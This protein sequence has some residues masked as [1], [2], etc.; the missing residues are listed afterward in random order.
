[1]RI[2]GIVLLMLLSW[3]PRSAEAACSGSGQSWSCTAGTTVAQVNS[4]LNAAANNATLT[5]DAG[6]YS[7]STAI[8]LPNTRGVTLRCAS[9]GNCNVAVGGTFLGLALSGNNTNVYRLSGFRFQNAPACLCIWIYGPGTLNNLRI[10]N[11]IFQNF[12]GDAIAIFF[13]ATD[14]AGSYYGVIDHNTFTGS[15]NFLALKV[16]GHGDTDAWGPSPKGTANNMF[17]EDNT[18]TFSTAANLGAGCMDVWNSGAVVWRYNT[19]TNCLVTAHGVSHGGVI[20]FEV[21]RNTLIRTA[22]SGGWENG[23]RLFHHQGSGEFIAFDNVFTAAAGAGKSASALAM[24]H[25]R[26]ASPGAAGYDAA[27]GRCDGSQPID[28]NRVPTSTYFG[29]PCW[30]QP[31][32]DGSQRL[33]P[34]YVWNNRWSDTAAKIDLYTENPWNAT[35]PGV[36]TH[37]LVNRDFYNAVSASAQ[38]SP[39]G[40]FNGTTGMGF[41]T[42]ANRPSTC[43]TNTQEAGGGVGYFATDQGP[44]GTLYR[45]SSANTWV[46]QYT[47][48]NYPHPLVSG[49]TVPAPT[50]AAPTNVRLLQ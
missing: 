7:W 3:A 42:L 5:F 26:S 15:A 27:L 8:N 39:T 10:D 35:S 32:R 22:N 49:G 23:T 33:Q 12:N 34:M 36:D 28:G 2:L 6:A 25:Y 45:C 13:G 14:T 30:R 31:G 19:S 21:Y 38:T 43:T 44:H 24:T 17:F 18:L 16:L 50:P 37:V 4:A 11:N 20:N 48:F 41:G 1:M 47:P 29:Y 9:S 46:V 40:P